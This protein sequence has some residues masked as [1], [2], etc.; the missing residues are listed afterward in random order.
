MNWIS[1]TM[2]YESIILHIKKI[3]M[4]R[5]I[6]SWAFFYYCIDCAAPYTKSQ[7]GMILAMHIAI[8]SI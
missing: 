7:F 3:K 2:H 1:D 5:T 8:P 4:Y 6:H